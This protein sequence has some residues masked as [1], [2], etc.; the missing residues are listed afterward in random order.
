MTD[1]ELP[2]LESVLKQCRELFDRFL[3]VAT[4]ERDTDIFETMNGKPD[5]ATEIIESHP[6]A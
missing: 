2:F 6:R 1:R 5:E 4:E 3:A